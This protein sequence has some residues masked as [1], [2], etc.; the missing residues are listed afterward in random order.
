[1]NG[2]QV[3]GDAFIPSIDRKAYRTSVTRDLN[4]NS[5]EIRKKGE[6]LAGNRTL[7]G[8]ADVMAGAVRVASVIANLDIEEAPSKSNSNHANIIGWDLNFGQQMI[9]AEDV[10]R[11]SKHCP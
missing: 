6:A 7:N 4:R 8:W 11:Q 1:M 2:G 9:Q 5:A 10:A 3:K